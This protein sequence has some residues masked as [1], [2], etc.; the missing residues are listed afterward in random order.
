MSDIERRGGAFR[1]G[2]LSMIA[3]ISNSGKSAFAQAIGI[4]TPARTLYFAAD[5]DEWTT[6]T[7]MSA[8]VTG[9][10]VNDVAAALAEGGDAG[11]FYEEQM[12]ADGIRYCFDSNPSLE[13]IGLEIDA[14]VDT[15]DE[16]PDFILIDNLVNIEASGEHQD[17]MFIMSELH[18]LARRTK[19]HV[20]VLA[21]MK[22]GGVKD[23]A[24][25]APKKDLYNQTQ[26]YPDLILSVALDP[27]SDTFRVAIVKTREGRA[28]PQAKAPVQLGSDFSTCRFFSSPRKSW[29]TTPTNGWGY[30]GEQ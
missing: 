5:Q 13:D 6:S 4:E 28:D 1:R 3:G 22:E 12:D 15:W 17:D 24:M 10:P 9:T 11:R 29:A 7:R 18:G 25:P 16:Y 23:P 19:A 20:C 26:R 30:G 8:N 2:H 21:H 14:W 27:E